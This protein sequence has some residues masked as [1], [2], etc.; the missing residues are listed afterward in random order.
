MRKQGVDADRGLLGLQLVDGV[1]RFAAFL[2][3]G[4]DAKRGDGFERIIW[5]GMEHARTKRDKVRSVNNGGSQ[6]RRD[7]DAFCKS[8]KLEQA[9]NSS[10]PA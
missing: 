9:D 10:G 5:F 7:Q 8:A 1:F 4:E 6:Q 2:L 3:D